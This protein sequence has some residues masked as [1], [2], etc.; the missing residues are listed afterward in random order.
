M[1]STTCLFILFHLDGDFV[2]WMC[3]PV[4]FCL[5][6]RLYSTLV[7]ILAVMNNLSIL[8]R[9]IEGLEERGLHTIAEKVTLPM[10]IQQRRK[11][12]PMRMLAVS[13]EQ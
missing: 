6:V 7:H 3:K 2:N 13:E 1:Q 10:G 8:T 11:S 9:E 12:L 4:L 5:V